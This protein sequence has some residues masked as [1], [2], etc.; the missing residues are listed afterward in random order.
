MRGGPN[1]DALRA[2]SP[3]A[4][5]VAENA[6]VSTTRPPPAAL[7]PRTGQARGHTGRVLLHELT[8]ALSGAAFGQTA[9]ATPQ[10]RGRRLHAVSRL[11]PTDRR[12]RMVG[13]TASRVPKTGA[14]A[15]ASP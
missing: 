2:R 12:R 4:R 11:P 3:A 15:H 1:A 5:L 8:T 6:E 13:P 10:R 14:R 9:V 7:R